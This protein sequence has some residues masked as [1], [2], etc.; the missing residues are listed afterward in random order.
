[1]EFRDVILEMKIF[2]DLE[3][4]K[5][6]GYVSWKMKTRDLGILRDKIERKK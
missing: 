4:E 5:T 1:M 6:E 2:M 3:L